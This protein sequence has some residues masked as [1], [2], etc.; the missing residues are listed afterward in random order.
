MVV[1]VVMGVLGAITVLSL[2]PRQTEAERAAR[3]FAGAVPGI[4]DRAVIEARTIGLSQ[5][6]GLTLHAYGPEGWAEEGRVPIEGEARAALRPADEVLP[7]DPPSGKTLLVYRPPGERLQ[8]EEEAAPPPPIAFGPTGE[9]TPFEA[10][11]TDEAG[12]WI[13]AVDAL[14]EAEVR[15]ER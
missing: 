15:R 13:V 10:A 6:D 7:P 12:S 8:E 9:V 2:P 1:V 3:A 11:F 14:G 5:A 4:A